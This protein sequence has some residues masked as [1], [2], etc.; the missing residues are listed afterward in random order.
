MRTMLRICDSFAADFDVIFNASKS[1]WLATIPN[2]R[3][4]MS[5]NINNCSF[6]VGGSHIELVDKFVHLGYVISSN[7]KDNDDIEARRSDIIAQVNNMSCFFSKLD[8]FT[9]F[10]L[11]RNYCF[12]Y[13]GNELGLLNT[14]NI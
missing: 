1:K 5:D 4:S 13:Y 9:R 11:F 10:S 12:S 3:Q 6:H 14:S 8:V 7:L 2:N